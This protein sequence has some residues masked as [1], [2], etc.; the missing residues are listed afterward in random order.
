MAGKLSSNLGL[1]LFTLFAFLA[2]TRFF[3]W[4]LFCAFFL[5]A[6]FCA[7]FLWVLFC[8]FL[9]RVFFGAFSCDYRIIVIIITITI[10]VINLWSVPLFPVER[11]CNMNRV[12]HNVLITSVLWSNEHGWFVFFNNTTS[13]A[14]SIFVNT[15]QHPQTV[16]SILHLY[17][18]F[19]NTLVWCIMCIM[20]VWSSQQI[21][22][23]ANK[24]ILSYL[25][26]SGLSRD[27]RCHVRLYF[28]KNLLTN[29]P[30]IRRGYI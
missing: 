18:Y 29:R 8:A 13:G 17:Q 28:F 4:A 3:L 27:I 30:C 23:K 1:P 9:F 7:F 15:S 6:L 11:G 14:I 22:A 19:C 12:K 16:I 26:L 25:I 21:P 5:W 24:L 10:I 2:L 20:F